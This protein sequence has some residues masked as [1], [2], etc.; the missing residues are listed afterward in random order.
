LVIR[1]KNEDI[2]KNIE[3]VISELEEIIKTRKKRKT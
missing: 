2:E 3:W 1:F